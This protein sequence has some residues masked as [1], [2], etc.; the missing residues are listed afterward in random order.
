MKGKN[1]AKAYIYTRVSTK[2]QVDGFSLTAQKTRLE[3]Y[4]EFN[5]MKIVGEYCDEGKSGKNDNRPEFQRMIADIQNKKDNVEYVLVFKMSRFARNA[6]D[7]LK[8]LQQIQKAGANLICVEEG[9]NSATPMG[10]AQLTIMAAVAEMELENI[11]TQTLAGRKEKAREG[12]WNGGFAP[13]GYALKDGKLVISE[14]EA[15]TIRY[16]FQIFTETNLGAIGVAKRLNAEGIKKV[17]RKNGKHEIF[18]ASFIKKVIDNPVYMGCISYG[19]RK[20]ITDENG[21]IHTIKTKDTDDIILS[22]G[23]HKAIVSEKVWNLAHTKR[24]ETGKKKEKIDPNHYYILSGLIRCPDCGKMM[25]GVPNRKKKP[26]GSLYKTSYAYKCR[27]KA[28]ETGRECKYTHQINCSEIDSEVLKAISLCFITPEVL[29]KVQE[30]LNQ[31]FDADALENKLKELKSQ[32]NK[33]DLSQRKLEEKQQTLDATDK[34]YDRKFDSITRQLE[35]IYEQ[36]DEVELSIMSME[37]KI[38]NTYASKKTKEDVLRYLMENS[39][40]IL[41]AS[42]KE[43]KERCNEMID[44][45]EVFPNKRESG[46]LKTIHFKVPINNNNNITDTLSIWDLDSTIDK[47]GNFDKDVK[48]PDPSEDPELSCRPNQ[49]PVECVVLMSRVDK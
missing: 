7:T 33:L 21:N 39:F 45:I 5:D 46:Y 22:K 35:T 40:S 6:T 48:E 47:D 28:H 15:P 42:D 23:I 1:I 10:K 17:V 19:R 31:S 44:Y 13:Y 18:T 43:K 12:K 32:K 20:S 36:L 34:Y 25:Y 3:K 24:I 30:K 29:D 41:S 37:S 11:H 4:A 9:M 26:D 38:A 27:Q 16:I 8:H 49:K 2:M 14:D